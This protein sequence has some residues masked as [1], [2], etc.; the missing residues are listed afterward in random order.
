MRD[1]TEQNDV[2]LEDWDLHVKD[3]VEHKRDPTGFDYTVYSGTL[4][5]TS[6][7]VPLDTLQKDI[8]WRIGDRMSMYELDDEDWHIYIN[9]GKVS[10][11]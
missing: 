2:V 4:T 10:V 3:S 7:S 11:A 6:A 5:W 1:A 8:D 9:P